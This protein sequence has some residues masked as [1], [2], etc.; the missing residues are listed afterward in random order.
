MSNLKQIIDCHQHFWRLNRGDYDWLN[1]GLG[2]LYKDYE[3]EDLEPILEKANIKKTILIQ[4]APT[5]EETKFMLSLA[6]KHPFIAGVIGWVD[7]ESAFASKEITL[8]SKHSKFKGVRPMIQNI[9]DTNW[10]AKPVL[11]PAINTL[12]TNGLRFE[13]LVLTQHLDSLISMIERNPKLPVAINH[14]AK[15]PTALNE[16]STW[17]KKIKH[18]ANKSNTYC[19]LSGLISE[20]RDQ[21]NIREIRLIFEH[22]LDCFGPDRIMW[23]SDWPVVRLRAEYSDWLSI[24][25]QLL[26]DL[27]SSIQNK[28]MNDNAKNFYN[29]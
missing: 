16:L 5:N 21:V 20:N 3:P 13:A 27:P 28:I 19:K 1:A 26:N 14:A 4:A 17:K 23:G 9:R 11:S 18:L 10:I 8:L 15:P 25:Q 7:L 24:T 22:L 6:D 12:I 2:K 29:I